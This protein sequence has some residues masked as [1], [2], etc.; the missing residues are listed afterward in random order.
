MMLCISKASPVPYSPATSS[1]LKCVCEWSSGQ[2]KRNLCSFLFSR[3]NFSLQVRTAGLNLTC[4]HPEPPDPFPRAASQPL[5]PLPHSDDSSALSLPRY[6]VC[7][8][9]PNFHTQKSN[10]PPQD[11]S[12]VEFGVCGGFMFA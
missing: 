6:G 9:F 10:P 1:C 2:R 7:I 3:I 11:T 8:L 5:A 12:L 4:S